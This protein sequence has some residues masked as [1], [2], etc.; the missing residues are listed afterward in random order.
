MVDYRRVFS[1]TPSHFITKYTN[2]KV[3]EGQTSLLEE[4]QFELLPT[5]PSF[6]DS[7]S[8]LTGESAYTKKVDEGQLNILPKAQFERL[9]ERHFDVLPTQPSFVDSTAEL[10]GK[11]K[12]TVECDVESSNP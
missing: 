5:Q 12:R 10:T 3:D 1:V 2:T 6:V 7:T 4:A 8:E 9:A 11:S